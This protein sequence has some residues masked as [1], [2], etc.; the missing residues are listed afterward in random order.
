MDL[1]RCAG[2]HGG[3]IGVAPRAE[4][5]TGDDPK[6]SSVGLESAG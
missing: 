6:P 2:L 4:H 5:P 3:V 1:L